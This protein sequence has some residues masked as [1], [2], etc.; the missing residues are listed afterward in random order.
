MADEVEPLCAAVRERRCAGA[1]VLASD[2][3]AELGPLPARRSVEGVA[4][5]A[6]GARVFDRHTVFAGGRPVVETRLGVHAALIEDRVLA[7]GA[8]LAGRWGR[9]GAFWALVPIEGF[10]L[11]LV[12]RPI[13]KLPPVGA[14]RLDDAPGT[15][16]MQ[17]QGRD[18]SD[19]VM[20]RRIGR[21]LTTY[22]D[23]GAPLS[24]AVAARGLRDGEPVPSEEVWP[25]GIELLSRGAAEGVFEPIAHGWLHYDPQASTAERVEPREFADLD[26]PEAGRR[27]DAA[28][29]WQRQFFGEP[30]TFVAPAWGYSDGTLRALAKRQLPAWHRAAAEPLIV[31]GNP[32]ETLIGPGG[33]GGVHRLDYGSLVRMA[34]SGLPPTPALHGGLMDDRLTSRVFRDA[35]GYARLLRK[36]DAHRLPGVEGIRWIGAAELVDLYRAHDVAGE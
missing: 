20:A 34:Q 27:I 36:R 11:E 14:V 6:S 22:R 10:L 30:R 5:F 17:L 9:L 35:A 29:D 19:E 24:V 13:L 1:I 7:L 28:I 16:Q 31:D 2:P 33:S 3:G 18:K 8:D 32:R 4:K 15:A 25:K 21:L 23:A 26:E 12:D